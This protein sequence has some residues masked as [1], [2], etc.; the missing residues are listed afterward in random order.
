MCQPGDAPPPHCRHARYVLLSV[1]HFR[2]SCQLFLTIVDG[3]P[4][5]AAATSVPT[6]PT[7]EQAAEAASQLASLERQL[8]RKNDLIVEL[9]KQ[10]EESAGARLPRRPSA[11][12]VQSSGPA[13]LGRQHSTSASGP[14]KRSR[15]S[16]EPLGWMGWLWG[17]LHG[18]VAGWAGSCQLG[19]GLPS[20]GGLL[21]PLL[22]VAERHC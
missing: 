6:G 13:P 1:T 22:G 18:W 15:L 10:L 12:S 9:S 19:F 8:D 17:P 21:V 20:M 11:R 7:A 14:T 4:A 5:E 16:C 3:S 2:E